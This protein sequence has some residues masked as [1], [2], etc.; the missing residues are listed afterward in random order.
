MNCYEKDKHIRGTYTEEE[1]RVLIQKKE[2]KYICFCFPSISQIFS[3]IFEA[4][5]FLEEILPNGCKYPEIALLFNSQNGVIETSLINLQSINDIKI[6]V[7]KK[8]FRKMSWLGEEYAICIGKVKS[9]FDDKV[10]MHQVYPRNILEGHLNRIKIKHNISFQSA[11]E[12]EFY[13]FNKP[14]D[15]II[16]TYPEINLEKSKISKRS[17]DY[18][19]LNIIEKN[20]KFTKIMKEN[21]LNSGVEIEAMFTE[22]GPGQHEINIKYS[23]VLHNCDNHVI[24]KQCLKHT[25]YNL[26]LGVSFMAKPFMEYDGSSSHVHISLYDSALNNLFSP[27]NNC[28]ENAE[29]KISQNFEKIFANKKLFFF[30]GGVLKYMKDLFLCYAPNVNSYKRF[31]K[32][33]FAPM[34]INTWCYDSRFSSVRVISSGKDNSLHNLHLEIRTGGSDCNPYILHTAIICS[35]M[36]GIE[37]EIMPPEMQVGNT[38]EKGGEGMVYPPENLKEAYEIFE[39]SEIAK[40]IFGKELHEA[41]VNTAKVEW[42]DFMNHISNWEINRYLSMA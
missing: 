26:N 24:L 11:S 12:L 4:K 6:E 20:E 17:S 25:G 7:D 14:T 5:Y 22:H 37:E 16:S 42:N 2:I 38:Y 3:K 15:D 32:Y 19:V 13:V 41:M 8:T 1:L 18:C 28:E 31:K 40:E 23:E 35:G 33:S 34:Y 21:L 30:I 10:I 29:I 27:S 39:K 9:R 36:K